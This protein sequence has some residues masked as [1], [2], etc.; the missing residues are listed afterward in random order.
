[1]T[2][3][4]SRVITPSRR[5][6]GFPLRKIQKAPP[7]HVALIRKAPFPTCVL[8]RSRSLTVL[9]GLI[10]TVATAMAEEKPSAIQNEPLYAL[11]RTDFKAFARQFGEGTSSEVG[12][13]RAIVRWLT[14]NFAWKTTDYQKRTV[15]EIIE[16][17]GGN[18]NDFSIVAL[19][20]MDE[21][22]IRARK[23]HEIH[24]RTNS[25][26]RGAR[27]DALVKEKGKS[28]S[29][30]GRHH[31]DH[32]WLEIYDS[33]ASERVPADPWSGLVGTEDWMKGR[34]W[35]GPRSSLNPD[36]ADMIVPIDLCRRHRWQVHRRSNQALPGG[37]V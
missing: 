37:R 18:C 26:E 21:L 16:R 19:A 15:P 12:R 23:V 2:K 32:V 25:V 27:A 22:K 24:I 13:T 14:R 17:R 11:A 9:L 34:V 35:F 29:V 5:C 30:F 1:M 8:A 4:T 33:T 31:N 10:V 28:S 36:A 20:V 6:L 3:S 7:E